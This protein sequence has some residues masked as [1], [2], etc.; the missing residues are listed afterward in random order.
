[1]AVGATRL[2]LVLAVALLPALWTGAVSKAQTAEA[3][4]VP[5]VTD[6]AADPGTLKVG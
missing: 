6:R 1:M 3:A 5:V 4:N 2:A